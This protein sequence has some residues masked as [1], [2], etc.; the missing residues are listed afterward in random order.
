MAEAAPARTRGEYLT[1][2]AT[3]SCGSCRPRTSANFGPRDGPPVVFHWRWWY[4]V[5]TLPLW[6]IAVVLVGLKANRHRQAWLIL[7]PLGL[8]FRLAHA[9][10]V[11]LHVG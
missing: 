10:D 9:G 6:A 3:A 1:A 4:H 11:V 7:V 8:V 2:L 5:P